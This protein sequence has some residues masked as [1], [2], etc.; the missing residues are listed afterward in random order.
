MKMSVSTN[1]SL[2]IKSNSNYLLDSIPLPAVFGTASFNAATFGATNDPMV[3]QAVEGS[4]NTCSFRLTSADQT[5][6]YSIN[7]I[8]VDYMPSG[9]R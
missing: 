7:G 6:P 2:Q 3:R 4:G 1:Y 8:Y 5:P 9:R